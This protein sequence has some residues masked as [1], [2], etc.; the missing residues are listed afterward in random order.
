MCLAFNA[1]LKI[2]IDSISFTSNVIDMFKKLFYAFKKL[3]VHVITCLLAPSEWYWITYKLTR[4]TAYASI[5]KSFMYTNT[6]E[7]TRAYK[8]NEMLALFTR[9]DR[10]FPIPIKAKG[11]DVFNKP[12]PNGLILCSVHIP[13]SKVA[14]RHLIEAGLQP[15]VAIAANPGVVDSI[16]VW[17]IR[18]KIP[19]IRTGS[20][21]LNRAK[22]ILKQQGT[23]VALVDKELGSEFSPNLFKLAHR[24]QADI[25]FFMAELLPNGYVE[26]SYYE[27]QFA[28]P[29]QN[30]I[31]KKQMYELYCHVSEILRRNGNATMTTPEAAYGFI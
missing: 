30:V 9:K 27:S 4:F 11:L 26:V 18:E 25:V 28:G 17:G 5:H 24:V 14:L 19:A 29:E 3:S 15:S 22:T 2:I 10:Y 23:V 31:I 13:L 8:L 6:Y 1:I 20:F 21:V 16:A 7:L 12:R